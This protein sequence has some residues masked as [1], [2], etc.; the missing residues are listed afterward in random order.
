MNQTTATQRRRLGRQSQEMI[1]LSR[2]A[3]ACLQRVTDL[4]GQRSAEVLGLD[5][6]GDAI[7]ERRKLTEEERVERLQIALTWLGK[8]ENTI[9]QLRAQIERALEKEWKCL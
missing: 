8:A 5:E 7:F 3:R 1:G 4:V 9:R 2:T 6:T